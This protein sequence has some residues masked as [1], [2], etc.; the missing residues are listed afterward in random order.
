MS[1][2]TKEPKHMPPDTDS[3]E[4]LDTVEE[5]TKKIQNTAIGMYIER[6]KQQTHD[7]QHPYEDDSQIMVNTDDLLNM[8]RF[9]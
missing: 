6:L 9:E 2:V 1:K 8:F 5:T 3:V 4:D 7:S